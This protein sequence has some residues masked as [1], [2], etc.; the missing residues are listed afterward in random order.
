MLVHGSDLPEFA[1]LPSGE[2]LNHRRCDR[3]SCDFFYTDPAG[4]AARTA[5]APRDLAMDYALAWLRWA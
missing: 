2:P 3:P 1:G 5:S 4:T